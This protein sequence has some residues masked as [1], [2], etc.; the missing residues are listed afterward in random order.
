MAT[1]KNQNNLLKYIGIAVVFLLAI[2]A[3]RL[4]FPPQMTSEDCLKL[5]SNYR[6]AKCLEEIGQPTPTPAFFS[7][8]NLLTLSDQKMDGNSYYQPNPTFH[9]DLHNGSSRS[10]QNI[11]AKFTFYKNTGSCDETPDDT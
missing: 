4:L 1:H 5:G 6:A 3:F 8:S 7:D 11:V 2:I 10:A 9:A